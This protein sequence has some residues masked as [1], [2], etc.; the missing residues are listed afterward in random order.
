MTEA[1][2]GRPRESIQLYANINRFLSGVTPD[3]SPSAFARA[4]LRAAEDGFEVIKCAPFDEVNS[5]LGT[6]E[7]TAAARTGIERVAAVRE[8]VGADV[9]LNVDCHCRFG[10]ESAVRVA[11]ELSE[12]DVAWFE[13][14]LCPQ[15]DTEGLALVAEQTA[16]PVAGGERGYGEAFFEDLVKRRAVAIAMPDVE[17]CGGVAEAYRAG[18]SALSAGGAVSLHCP[19]GPVSLIA[20]AHVHAA[21][22]QAM[23][24]EHAVYEAP[25]RAELVTPPERIKGGHLWL[26]GGPGTGVRLDPATVKRYGRTLV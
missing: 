20:S 22:P 21:I 11:E 14:A 5:E 15:D 3:R 13:E 7:Q 24:L 16:I 25:W 26:P 12:L 23:A 6:Q 1:L 19:S 18:L 17:Y 8:A 9:Q 4:A 10:V 2:G